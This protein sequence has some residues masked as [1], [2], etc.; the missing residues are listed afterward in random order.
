MFVDSRSYFISSRG[1][2]I[3]VVDEFKMEV[4]QIQ[5][6]KLKKK[7]KENR[8]CHAM[9]DSGTLVGWLVGWCAWNKLDNTIIGLVSMT[10]T[11]KTI[12]IVATPNL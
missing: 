10:T 9:H 12:I 8:T 11:T 6:E 3:V 7:K 1:E 4:E 2:D 5:R